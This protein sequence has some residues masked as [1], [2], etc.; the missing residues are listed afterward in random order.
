MNLQDGYRRAFRTA[1]GEVLLIHENGQSLL[2]DRHCPHAGQALD[3]APISDG[4]ITCP[5]H[6]IRFSLSSGHPHT[7]ACAA[8]RVHAIAYEGNSLGIDC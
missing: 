4:C 1:F 8:L 5:L 3:R 7:P 6:G 2:I